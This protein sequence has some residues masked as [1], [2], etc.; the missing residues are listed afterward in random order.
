MLLE[1]EKPKGG[2]NAGQM[3]LARF[4]FERQGMTHNPLDYKHLNFPDSADASGI[5]DKLQ[6]VFGITAREIPD[7]ISSP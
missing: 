2:L 7:P 6:S 5:I 4:A 3:K 1:I